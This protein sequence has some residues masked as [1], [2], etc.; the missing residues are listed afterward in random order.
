MARMAMAAYCIYISQCVRHV[1][2][3]TLANTQMRSISAHHTAS[4]LEQQRARA[5]RAHT[6]AI[7]LSARCANTL[8]DHIH[9]IIN[10]SNGTNVDIVEIAF[11]HQAAAAAA[12]AR[13]QHG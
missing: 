7:F 6:N 2:I 8:Y 12:A 5:Q 11:A 13:Q 1:H 9:Y 3:R 10:V 4:Q